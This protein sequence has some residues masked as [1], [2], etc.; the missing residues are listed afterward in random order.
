[1]NANCET[2][3]KKSLS[4]QVQFYQP[5]VDIFEN[6][7]EFLLIVDLPGS[8][9]EALDVEFEQGKLTIKGKAPART[10]ENAKFLAREFGVA[11]YYRS[12]EF[13]NTFDVDSMTAEYANGVLTVSLKKPKAATMRK[14]PITTQN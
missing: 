8:S 4:E 6:D 2:E 11:D 9:K 1:M 12:F 5:D 14:I 3:A 10:E 13:G 7:E